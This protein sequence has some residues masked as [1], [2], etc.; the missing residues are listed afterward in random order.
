MIRKTQTVQTFVA[1]RCVFLYA[2]KT[3]PSSMDVLRL[4]GCHGSAHRHAPCARESCIVPNISH[5]FLYLS[6]QVPICDPHIPTYSLLYLSAGCRGFRQN[7][8]R[9]IRSSSPAASLSLQSSVSLSLP[10]SHFQSLP[11]LSDLFYTHRS[12]SALPRGHHDFTQF[13]DFL[14]QKCSA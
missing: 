4:R 9:P 12:T 7:I 6:P 13:S 2:C 3:P 1:A 10:K 14:R 11:G 8:S 5:D